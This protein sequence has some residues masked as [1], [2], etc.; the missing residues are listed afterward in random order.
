M[1][2][3]WVI[4]R[5]I[6]AVGSMTKPQLK[7]AA[8]TSNS[9]LSKLAPKVQWQHSYVDMDKT[10]CSYLAED[11]NATREHAKLS[12]FPASKITEVGMIIDPHHGRELSVIN[13][14]ERRA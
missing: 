7:G 11:Q 9:A 13:L 14:T 3:H 2:K 4:E 10:F 8:E 5:D 12:G 6:P 1:L